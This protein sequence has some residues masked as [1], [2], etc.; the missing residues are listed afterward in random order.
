[1]AGKGP[2]PGP[3]A[4]IRLG[5]RESE[6]REA[7]QRPA[8]LAAQVLDSDGLA[9]ADRTAVTVTVQGGRPGQV[10]L[11]TAGGLAGAELALTPGQGAQITAQVEGVV[12]TLEAA[13]EGAERPARDL[14]TTGTGLWPG[15]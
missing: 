2:A 3:A 5:L 15:G 11:Y 13:A 9:V 14:Q 12:A 7:G 6:R 4:R 1:M 8:W 10:V